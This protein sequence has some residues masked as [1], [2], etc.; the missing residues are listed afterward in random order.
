MVLEPTNCFLWATLRREDGCGGTTFWEVPSDFGFCFVL[1]LHCSCSDYG[2][3]QLGE[4]R[5][6]TTALAVNALF[7]IWTEPSETNGRKW[8]ASTPKSVQS[9]VFGAIQYLEDRI[10]VD[11]PMNAFFSGSVKG[12]SSLPMVYPATYSRLLN[13]TEI[14]PRSPNFP[15]SDVGAYLVYGVDGVV[16][17]N[18]YEKMV[19]E[20]WFGN[21]VPI[22]NVTSR[23]FNQNGGSW[24]PFWSSPSLTWATTLLAFANF[25]SLVDK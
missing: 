7:D 22:A 8:M 16:Q 17:P 11:E 6:F 15:S 24:F 23:S 25:N 18:V 3:H 9:A 21:N 5:L 14:D 4:D 13:G 12:G 20:T 19:N 10:F 1:F 2:K